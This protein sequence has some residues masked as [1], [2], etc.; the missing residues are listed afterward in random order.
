V[1]GQADDLRVLLDAAAKG[2]RAAFQAL[3]AKTAPKLFAIILRIMRDKAAA[4]DIL[5][6]T[7][8]RVWQKAVTYSSAAGEPMGWLAS[9]AR[10]R[11]FDVLRKKNPALPGRDEEDAGWFEKITASHD[12][13]AYA[14]EL[15]ALRHCLQQVEAQVRDCILLAYYEGY[16]REELASRYDRP[17]NTIKTWL[18]R[19][20]AALKLCLDAQR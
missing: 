17:V 20:L 3:Y 2:E 5:Q 8:L 12:G 9:I 7:Y 18:H 19:G 14:A 13:E 11:A 4:E 10:N 16:S 15:S 1:A 6:D